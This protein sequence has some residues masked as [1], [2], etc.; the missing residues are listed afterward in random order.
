MRP[1]VMRRHRL[2]CRSARAGR[3]EALR[4]LMEETQLARAPAVPPVPI[5]VGS[6]A[7]RERQ[8]KMLQVD[9]FTSL[10]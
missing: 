5:L 1:E 10:E 3:G 7:L 4:T 2:E 6:R 9:S 8:E